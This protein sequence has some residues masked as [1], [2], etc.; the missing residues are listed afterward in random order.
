MRIHTYEQRI[1]IADDGNRLCN[2]K[3]KSISSDEKVY[4]AINAVAEDWVEITLEEAENLQ[5][6]WDEESAAEV[7]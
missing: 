2:Y 3:E 1:L 5:K 6:Q 7:E 4:L